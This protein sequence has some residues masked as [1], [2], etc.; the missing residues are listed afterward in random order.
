MATGQGKGR[1]R[2]ENQNQDWIDKQK[3][4]KETG[5]AMSNF[6]LFAVAPPGLESIVKSELQD[7]GISG[8]KVAGGVEFSGGLFHLCQANL[9]L[10]TASRVLLRLGSF[11]LTS[12]EQAAERFS[13]YPWE[14]YLRPS[15]PIRFRITCHKSKIFHSGALEERLI[16]GIQVRLGKKIKVARMSDARS[17]DPLIVLR[18]FRDNCTLSIDSSGRHLHYRG[19][20]TMNVTAPLRENLAAAMLLASGWDRTS[21]LLDPFCGSGTILIEAALMGMNI[22]PGRFRKFA[23]QNW[24]NFDAA[25][26]HRVVAAADLERRPLTAQ[27]KGFDRSVQAIE[28]AEANLAACGLFPDVTV[29]QRELSMLDSPASKGWLVTNSPYGKRLKEIHGLGGLYSEFGEII[30][31]RFPAW[32][33]AMLSPHPFLQRATKLAFRSVATFS[34]GGIRVNL[35][36]HK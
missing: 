1:T 16:K 8:R 34:N 5:A 19:L 36:L 11:R 35:L 9:W 12:L 31:E 23:F 18:L 6:R 21:P 22:P 33:V 2:R 28:A 10:R 30:R 29:E 4:P 13:R 32:T 15:R 14:I 25:M 3:Q 27:I 7:L 24:R 20:K 26:W 17:D